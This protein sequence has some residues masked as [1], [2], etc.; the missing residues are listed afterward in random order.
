MLPWLPKFKESLD[1]ESNTKRITTGKNLINQLKKSNLEEQLWGARTNPRR[2]FLKP[3]RNNLFKKR[4]QPS[5]WTPLTVITLSTAAYDVSLCRFHFGL[6]C[7]LKNSIDNYMADILPNIGLS[8]LFSSRIRNYFLF[9]EVT[10]NIELICEITQYLNIRDL[11]S[12]LSASTHTY[13]F[14]RVTNI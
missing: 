1:W 12:F 11:I 13:S 10:N 9:L 4:N 3:K 8:K 7:L 14:S 6:Y 2:W 5:I